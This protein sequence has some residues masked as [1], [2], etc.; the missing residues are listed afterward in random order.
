MISDF[1]TSVD[2]SWRGFGSIPKSGLALQSKYKQYD[3]AKKFPVK[4]P[5]C[6]PPEGCS[7]GEVLR[8]KF[9][10]SDC[11]LFGWECTP[12]TPVGPCMVSTEG[13]CAAYY[14]YE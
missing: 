13:A 8:G 9:K 14:L 1:F 3:A 7:C 6:L 11:P 10:P 12:S 2:A 5:K 4:V